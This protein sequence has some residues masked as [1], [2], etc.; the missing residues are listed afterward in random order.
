MW[1]F[2]NRS[3]NDWIFLSGRVLC[4]ALDS[5]KQVLYFNDITQ[6]RSIFQDLFRYKKIL[7]YDT[8]LFKCQANCFFLLS[9]LLSF[10]LIDERISQQAIAQLI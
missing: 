1:L 9:C 7:G 10:S 6:K 2:K 8:I 5:L 3:V 4:Y